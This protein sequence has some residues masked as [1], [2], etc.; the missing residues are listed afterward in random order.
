MGLGG[1]GSSRLQFAATAFEGN[2][3]ATKHGGDGNAI[4]HIDHLKG[5]ELGWEK[6]PYTL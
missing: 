1:G 6:S 4:D 5:Q 3:A 2:E